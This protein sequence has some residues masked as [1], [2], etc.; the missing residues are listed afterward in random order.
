VIRVGTP[1][2]PETPEELIKP[3]VKAINSRTK[4]LAFSHVSNVSG[5]RLAA[6]ELCKIARD[7][8][9]LTLVDGAQTFGTY[10][11]FLKKMDCD[12]Y[13]ASSH[14]WFCGP[15]EVG[16]LYVRKERIGSLHPSNVGVGWESA[17]ENGARKFET[18]G[19]QDDSRIAA[20]NEALQFHHTLG[21]LRISTR[22]RMLADA[23]KEGLIK[24]IP[25]VKLLTPKEHPLSWGV[26][27]F[28]IPGLDSSQ[29][30]EALYKKFDIG[31]AAMGPHIR[32]SP[33]FYNTLEEV[34]RAVE[35]VAS[36][37]D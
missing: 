20:M 14:K 16:V 18:L 37:I 31:C 11:L 13:T 30:L 10:P 15:K 35:A 5:V 1:E 25:K 4:L 27:V 28:N 22:A 26:V 7:K 34:D 33:H 2:S 3:F 17:R 8:G 9:I 23:V 32:Y 19:Q 24:R 21:I 12:F 29:A 36:L 6:D